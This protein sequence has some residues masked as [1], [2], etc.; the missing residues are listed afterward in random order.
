[1]APTAAR[2]ACAP[3]NNSQSPDFAL[4]VRRASRGL[5]FPC[6]NLSGKLLSATPAIALNG[7]NPAGSMQ[8]KT[9]GLLRDNNVDRHNQSAAANVKLE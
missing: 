4:A 7:H 8:V 3:R 1:M 5:P 2:S 6:A 9:A